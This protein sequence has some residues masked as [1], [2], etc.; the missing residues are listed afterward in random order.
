MQFFRCDHPVTILVGSTCGNAFH[1][2]AGVDGQIRPLFFKGVIHCTGGGQHDPPLRLQLFLQGNFAI[3]L[4]NEFPKGSAKA[5]VENE[6]LIFGFAG[7][8][9]VMDEA[10]R[11][12]G[13]REQAI[14][15]FFSIRSSKVEIAAIV[16]NAMSRKEQQH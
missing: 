8:N 14:A 2:V 13:R 9:P 1:Q 4:P 11:S 5:A 3:I 12:R 6:H 15:L 10:G 7:P 16:F